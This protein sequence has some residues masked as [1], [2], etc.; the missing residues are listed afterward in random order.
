MLNASRFSSEA[1]DHP[2]DGGAVCVSPPTMIDI[3][4]RHISTKPHPRDAFFGL[5]HVFQAAIKGNVRR[6]GLSREVRTWI[7]LVTELSAPYYGIPMEEFADRASAVN[8]AD[9]IDQPVLVLHAADDFLVPVQHAYALQDA[10]ADN[11]NIHIMVRDVGA[12]VSFGAVDPSWYFSTV[13]RWVEYW[14]TPPGD[15]PEDAP[16]D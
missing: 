10:A 16:I 9:R 14:A 12:H 15:E 11:E 5:W 3:A 7:D 13:R 2:L 6:L 4:L 1:E 8:F